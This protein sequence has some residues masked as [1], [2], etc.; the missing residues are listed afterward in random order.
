MP[1]EK[2]MCAYCNATAVV[3]VNS[4]IMPEHLRNNDPEHLTCIGSGCIGR[5]IDPQFSVPHS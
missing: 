4:L 1:E 3:A 5:R 2:I